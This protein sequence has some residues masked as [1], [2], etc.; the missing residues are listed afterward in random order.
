[1]SQAVFK[2]AILAAS[3]TSM[4]A[5]GGYAVPTSGVS[6]D[7][8]SI[9][10]N[11][12]RFAQQQE[13]SESLFGIKAQLLSDLQGLATECAEDDWDGY[14]AEAVSESVLIRAEA[15]I[16]ALPENI[17]TPELSAEPDG[18]ISF[19][20]L[21]S[22]TKTFS[23][24]VNAGNRVAYAWIDGANRGHAAELFDGRML[25]VRALEELQRVVV[26]GASLRTA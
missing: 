19:D 10:E 21:P 4:A 5:W 25:P 6:D 9:N 20:W 1:M 3:A 15:F 26:D 17:P 13:L 2:P 16:R 23:L 18:E 24:S 14:G 11:I 22:R 12:K 8:F 7:A